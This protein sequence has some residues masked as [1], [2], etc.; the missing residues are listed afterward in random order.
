MLKLLFVTLLLS[1]GF[2]GS[3]S[4]EFN[5]G[6]S[7]LQQGAAWLTK[8]INGIPVRDLRE[9][10]K[11][12]VKTVEPEMYTDYNSV[13]ERNVGLSGFFEER[14]RTNTCFQNSAR[15]FYHEVGAILQR[16]HPCGDS[17]GRPDEATAYG[18]VRSELLNIDDFAGRGKNL[19]LKDGWLLRLALKHANNNVP[20]ALELIALCGHDDKEQG[21]YGYTDCTAKGQ[22]EVADRV[23]QFQRARDKAAYELKLAERNPRADKEELARKQTLVKSLTD[24]MELVSGSKCSQNYLVCPTKGSE[25]FL[26]GSLSGRAAIT[27]ELI[28]RIKNIQ[29]VSGASVFSPKEYHVYSS[30]YL[31]CKM[32]QK[33]M[34]PLDALLVQTTAARLYRGIRMCGTTQEL[35]SKRH[36]LK[37]FEKDFE[38][39]GAFG[40][41]ILKAW[42]KKNNGTLNCDDDSEEHPLR[43]CGALRA[44]EIFDLEASEVAT[45]KK[46]IARGLRRIDAATLY[47]RWYIGGGLIA[48]QQMPCTDLRLLGPRDLMNA[49]KGFLGDLSRPA[50]WS[51]ARFDLAAKE[52]AGWDVDFE[53][54][55]AQHA[56]GVRF[57][58]MVCAGTPPEANPFEKLGCF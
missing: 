44:L 26:P 9:G 15:D 56:A 24:S 48:G 51:K 27:Q 34:L 20:A 16:Q 40:Q 57:G 21:S 13:R 43:E 52:L 36:E 42:T 30:A 11:D 22:R 45:V 10:L 3:A 58:A 25:F 8:V 53:W 39:S 35:L 1:V 17:A 31:G 33:G 7:G 14:F 41:A 19:N 6:D 23:A 55:V 5:D 46:K 54:T 28:N 12:Y 4:A 18:C 37:D 2:A 47:D 32:V 29:G 49:N 50:G 38:T